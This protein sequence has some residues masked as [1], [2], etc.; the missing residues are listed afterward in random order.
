MV[1]MEHYIFGG[2]GGGGGGAAGGYDLN[3]DWD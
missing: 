3:W 2:K 1:N